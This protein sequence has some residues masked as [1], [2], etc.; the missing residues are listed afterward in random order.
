MTNDTQYANLIYEYFF[1]RFHFQYYKF[2]D[3]LPP[4]DILCREFN[5]SAQTVKS[6]LRRLRA[7]GYISMRNGMYTRVIFKQTEQELTD[8]VLRYFSERWES[9]ADLY[10]SA[11]LV[12]IPLLTE[13]L[14]RMDETDLEYISSLDERANADDLI[15]FYCYTLQKLENPLALNLFWEISLFQGFPFA[16]LEPR[17][18]HYDADLV[19]MRLKNLISYV[20][21][22]DWESAQAALTDNQRSDIASV[23]ENL[24]PYIHPLPKE[25]QIP[26]VWRVY[27]ERP[28]ICY[29]LASNILHEIYLGEFR[30]M[31]FMPSYEKMAQKYGVSVSTMRRTIDMLNQIGATQTVNGR[32]TRVFTVGMHS[33]GPNFENPSIRRNLSFYLQSFEIFIYSC[34]GVTRDLLSSLNPKELEELTGQLENYLQSGMCELSIWY[35]MIYISEHSRLAGIREIY[36]TIYHL[37]LWGYPMKAAAGNVPELDRNMRIFTER[38]VQHL[39]ENNYDRCAGTVK[40]LLNKLFPAATKHLLRQGMLPEELRLSPSIRLFLSLKEE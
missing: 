1:L 39:K 20:R 34:E 38:M 21:E 16:R 9:Y 18:I 11:E 4:I 25:E 36:R 3:T 27:R 31:E 28:Q 6:A 22:K 5:V 7:N 12:F 37:F 2:G 23:T 29:N 19:S 8:F 32:G 24:K 17:P 40:D 10:A 35:Y 30:N 14:K 13:C 15:H 33:D 26:F